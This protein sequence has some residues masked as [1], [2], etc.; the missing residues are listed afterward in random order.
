MCLYLLLKTNYF[1]IVYPNAKINLGLNILRKRNDGYHDISSLFYPLKNCVDI[2]EV[3]RSNNFAFTK[4]GIEI[5][6]EKNICVKAW[7]LINSEFRIGNVKIHL[8]KQIPIGAGLG[9]GSADAAFTLMALND[10]YNLNISKQ[11]FE[12][13]AIQLGA[14]CPFF[15][16]NTPKIVEGI[17]DKMIR[18]DVNLSDFEIKLVIPDFSISTKE[19][20]QNISPLIPQNNL[21]EILKLPLDTWKE[22]L[23]ND[24]EDTIFKKYPNLDVIKKELYNQGAIYASM[25]G[26]GSVLYGIFRK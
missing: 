21:R 20:Y 15:I 4:S 12:S 24:F 18:Y 14:D 9:G 11:Q 7:E 26:T 23:K 8:H 1:M 2:L 5:E 13:Y 6:S 3:V 17:G 22:N 10:I 16:D 25:T 19:A